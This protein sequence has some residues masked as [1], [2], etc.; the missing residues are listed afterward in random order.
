MHT[1]TTAPTTTT[2]TSPLL[3]AWRN[4]RRRQRTLTYT[5][6][7]CTKYAPAAHQRIL[8]TKSGYTHRG[9]WQTA[10]ED[11]GRPRR[12][13]LGSYTRLQPL[14]RLPAPNHPR[15]RVSR[16][17]SLPV[18]HSIWVWCLQSGAGAE[19]ALLAEAHSR[20]GRC[21]CA[22]DGVSLQQGATGKCRKCCAL[23]WYAWQTEVH[24]PFAPRRPPTHSRCCYEVIDVQPG[25]VLESP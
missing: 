4:A 2:E 15:T 6:P 19:D 21:S 23:V 20:P 9:L 16:N 22:P 5:R 18:Q 7:S 3:R 11:V 13:A 1:S 14:A 17:D 24:S 12:H 8:V 25:L 10:R